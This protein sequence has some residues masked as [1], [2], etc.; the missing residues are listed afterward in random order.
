MP[1]HCGVAMMD[2]YG[3]FTMLVLVLICFFVAALTA[4]IV[5]GFTETTIANEC[6]AYSAA[7]IDG[8]VYTCALR[9]K[10]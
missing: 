6:Q 9:G 5:N 2:D 7:T 8:K 10:I 3:F 1:H 4:I